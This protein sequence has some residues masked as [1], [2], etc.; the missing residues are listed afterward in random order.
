MNPFIRPALRGA[1]GAALLKQSQARVEVDEAADGQWYWH[2]RAANQR[3][4]ADAQGYD[5]ERGAW[6][7]AERARQIFADLGPLV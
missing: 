4:V 6:L 7:A 1:I 5:T 3:I 2:L